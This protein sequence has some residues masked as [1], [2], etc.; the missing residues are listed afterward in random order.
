MLHTVTI[1][2]ADSG[3]DIGELVSMSREFPFVEWAI[4]V[5]R[6]NFDTPRWP[7]RDWIR[8][9]SAVAAHER[10]KVAMHLCGGWV[11]ELLTGDLDFGEVPLGLFRVCQR[12]QI[13]THAQKH[14]AI[15]DFFLQLGDMP[16]NKQFIFQIDGVNDHLAYAAKHLGLNAVGLFDTSHGAGVL[17]DAWPF[18]T[19]RL[20]CGFAGGLGP[21]NV[22]AEFERIVVAAGDR[23]FWIDMERRVRSEDDSV[24]DMAKVRTVLELMAPHVTA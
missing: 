5:S 19:D 17:P 15:Y 3:T 4:L 24:L 21:E 10:M 6:N 22:V 18:M 8:E 16:V 1:T 23:P 13:N 7:S 12:I 20:D 14:L 9:F 2:G 11:R